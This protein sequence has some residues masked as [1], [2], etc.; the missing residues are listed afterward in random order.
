MFRERIIIMLVMMTMSNRRG[1]CNG[2]HVTT[3]LEVAMETAW[4]C[5][6]LPGS[7]QQIY[8]MMPV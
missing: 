7:C 8:R 6:L 2:S 1:E 3:L 4:K 5:T